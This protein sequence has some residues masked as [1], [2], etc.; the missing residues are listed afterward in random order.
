MISDLD[1]SDIQDEKAREVIGQ[2]L[3]LVENEISNLL[4]Q[5]RESFHAEK[6]ALYAA[7][8]SVNWPGQKRPGRFLNDLLFSD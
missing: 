8:L 3:N 1:L 2:L 4:I 5:E 6:D 7:G